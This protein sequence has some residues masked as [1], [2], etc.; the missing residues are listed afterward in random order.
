[1]RSKFNFVQRISD[2]LAILAAVLVAVLTAILAAVLTAVLTA[3]LAAYEFA[4]RILN[5]RRTV[6]NN[7][8][9]AIRS[10]AYSPLEHILRATNQIERNIHNRICSVLRHALRGSQNVTSGRYNAR[11]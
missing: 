10:T 2:L 5:T 6:R 4:K 7:P 11:Q 3:A 8:R 9:K 1:M